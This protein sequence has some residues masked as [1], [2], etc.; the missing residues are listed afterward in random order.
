M[1]EADKDIFV[2]IKLYQCLTINRL[3]LIMK[4]LLL[5]ENSDR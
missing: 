2:L 5:V 1:I 3:K 4:Y